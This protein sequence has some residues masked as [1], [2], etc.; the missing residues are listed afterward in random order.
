MLVDKN[1]ILNSKILLFQLIVGFA[2]LYMAPSER[3]ALF[4][5]RKRKH[6]QGRLTKNSYV[7]TIVVP[8]IVKLGGTAKWRFHE[9]ASEIA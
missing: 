7:R 3:N 6:Q 4:T 1:V 2:S 5:K 9:G 8:S